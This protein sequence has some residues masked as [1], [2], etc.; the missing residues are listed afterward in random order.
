MNLK[1]KI[2]AVIVT[3][4]YLIG[5]CYSVFMIGKPPEYLDSF[6]IV[7]AAILTLI[8]SEFYYS[9]NYKFRIAFH[10]IIYFMFIIWMGI[11]FDIYIEFNI[12][13]YNVA[14]VSISPLLFSIISIGRFQKYQK[15]KKESPG[16]EKF[17]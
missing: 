8:V 6:R 9:M 10:F 3:I 4:G 11:T 12:P 5:F 17:F 16:S 2:T 7:S 14:I 13:F 15:L 1:D